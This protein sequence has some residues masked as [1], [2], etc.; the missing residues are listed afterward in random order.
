MPSQTN[1]H[2]VFFQ[3]NPEV[4]IK[5]SQVAQENVWEREL[6]SARVSASGWRIPPHAR[7]KNSCTQGKNVNFS[8]CLRW[9]V[10]FI[11]I[12]FISSV[13][14]IIFLV[15]YSPID[16]ATEFFLKKTNPFSMTSWPQFIVMAE[17][18]CSDHLARSRFL[19]LVPQE[20]FSFWLSTSTSSRSLKT[21]KRAWAISTLNLPLGQYKRVSYYITKN[22]KSK[23]YCKADLKHRVLFF[24]T[25]FRLAIPAFFRCYWTYVAITILYKWRMSQ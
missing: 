25:I 24:I 9:P 11:F 20:K 8:T 14:K 7:K 3:S 23:D 4:T 17:F 13:D 15:F 1:L 12:P 2:R 10:Y 21:Q 18:L 6:F 5:R 16:A 19:A 22:E